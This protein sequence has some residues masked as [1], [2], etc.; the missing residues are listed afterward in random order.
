[1]PEADGQRPQHLGCSLGALGNGGG[2]LCQ[3]PR[4]KPVCRRLRH[5]HFQ[6]Q[7]LVL[8]NSGDVTTVVNGVKHT[9]SDNRTS[10]HRCRL[11]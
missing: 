1:M 7:A 9:V 11:R 2:R 5:T 4:R 6:Q 8:V 3:S 10:L